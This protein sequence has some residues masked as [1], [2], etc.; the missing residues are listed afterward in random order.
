L[1]IVLTSFTGAL[2]KLLAFVEQRSLRT[3]GRSQDRR[4]IGFLLRYFRFLARAVVER[5]A[6]ARVVRRIEKEFYT[7]RRMMGIHKLMFRVGLT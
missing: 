2:Q 4:S 5:R 3:Q 1:E 7:E 6:S